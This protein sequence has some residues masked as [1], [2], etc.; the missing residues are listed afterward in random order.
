MIQ[1]HVFALEACLYPSF[2]PIY[3][4]FISTIDIWQL[5]SC[6]HVMRM[7]DMPWGIKLQKRMRR[8]ICFSCTSQ[9]ALRIYST[10]ELNGLTQLL[11]LCYTARCFR[12]FPI[13]KDCYCFTL[14]DSKASI[15]GGWS[16]NTDTSKPVVG[17]MQIIWP[18]SNPATFQSLAQRAYQLIFSPF[19]NDG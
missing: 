8:G 6:Q 3:L 7:P 18:L 5:V 14:T 4:L 9:A 1:L 11:I 10:V 15:R 17:Y 13:K 2:S 12:F 16:Y 19:I